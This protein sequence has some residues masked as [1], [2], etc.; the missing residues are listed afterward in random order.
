M[1]TENNLITSISDAWLNIDVNDSEI[2]SPFSL[3]TEHDF[4]TKLT[5]LLTNP[6]YFS[7]TCKEIFNVEL[8]PTQALMLKEMWTRKFPMLIASRGFGKCLTL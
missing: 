3:Q 5:W 4:H 1:K 6:D 8:L 2:V 7:F